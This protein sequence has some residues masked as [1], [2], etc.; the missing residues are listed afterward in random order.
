LHGEYTSLKDGG[1]IKYLFEVEYFAAFVVR[2]LVIV[3]HST[4]EQHSIHS[5]KSRLL[6][7]RHSPCA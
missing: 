2:E 1:G 7:R 5:R 3:D 4:P 6:R